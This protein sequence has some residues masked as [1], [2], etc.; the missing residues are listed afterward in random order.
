MDECLLCGSPVVAMYGQCPACKEHADA[1]TTSSDRVKAAVRRTRHTLPEHW[2]GL[3][4][5]RS[6]KTRKGV[7]STYDAD[8]SSIEEMLLGASWEEISHGAVM[9]GCT[10]FVAALPGM[11]GVV[12]LADLPPE[13]KLSLEDSHST[14]KVEC[15]VRGL[16][17]ERWEVPQ[18]WLIVGQEDG[19]E[20]VYTFHPGEP[21]RPSEIGNSI[22]G[23]VTHNE[24]KKLGFIWV[25]VGD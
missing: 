11:A 8:I 13:A 4:L 12:R 10:A 24:A 23:D 15:V 14:G 18:T 5:S 1:V 3:L 17:L 19:V 9:P 21:V 20:V 22:S 7:G 2:A 25:K 16:A 6:A